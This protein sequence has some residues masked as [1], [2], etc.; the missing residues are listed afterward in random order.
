MKKN[1]DE[2]TP[3]QRAARLYK[4]ARNHE[5]WHV[6]FTAQAVRILEEAKTRAADLY[7]TAIQ[8]A[9]AATRCRVQARD[10]LRA[11]EATP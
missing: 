4:E 9:D 6:E 7:Q 2:M 5:Y 11:R 8:Q 10:I 1:W 3:G